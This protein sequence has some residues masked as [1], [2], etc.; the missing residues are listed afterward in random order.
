M[1]ILL[2]SPGGAETVDSVTERRGTPVTVCRA[3]ARWMI[4]ER[5]APQ[6][7]IVNVIYIY[8]HVC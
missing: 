5:P 6:E 7:T 2:P 4:A 1:R 3:D 8:I